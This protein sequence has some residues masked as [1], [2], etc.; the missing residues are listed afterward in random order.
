MNNFSIQ[1]SGF[2]LAQFDMLP[3]TNLTHVHTSA[4]MGE[5]KRKNLDTLGGG[6]LEP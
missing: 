6:L 3:N 4:K 2:F 1:N 5:R